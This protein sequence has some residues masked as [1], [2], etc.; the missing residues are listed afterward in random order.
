MQLL[1]PWVREGQRAD[2]DGP[3]AIDRGCLDRPAI[4]TVRVEVIGCPFSDAVLPP[5]QLKG[6]GGFPVAS[7]AARSA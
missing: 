2:A 4:T 6:Q 3:V 1:A 5:L 7:V